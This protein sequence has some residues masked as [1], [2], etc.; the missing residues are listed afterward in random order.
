MTEIYIR[1]FVSC[2]LLP[3]SQSQAPVEVRDGVFTT[4]HPG[5]HGR[6]Q[7]QEVKVDLT[8]QH[9][10]LAPVV[11]VASPFECYEDVKTFQSELVRN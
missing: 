2:R 11:S 9:R 10:Y 6:P 8:L 5:C 3:R 4:F 7:V 1:L